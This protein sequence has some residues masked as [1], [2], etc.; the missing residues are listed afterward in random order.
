MDQSDEIPVTIDIADVGALVG[1]AIGPGTWHLVD[2]GRVDLF[3]DATGDHQWI[4]VDPERAGATGFGGTVAHG[5]LTLSMLPMMQAELRRFAGVGMAVNYG[6]EKVRFP[7]PVKV[8]SRVR[9]SLTVIDAEA[10]PD[11]STL[12]RT[13]ARVEVEDASRPACVAETLTLLRP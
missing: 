8:G 10:R 1:R 5:Y 2:Q 3:A 9:L 12:V 7:T 6:L 13:E 4:H 11:G